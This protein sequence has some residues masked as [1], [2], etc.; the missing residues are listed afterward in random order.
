MTIGFL[1]EPAYETSVSLLAEAVATSPK[2]ELRLLLKWMQVQK[3]FAAMK[4][5]KKPG[6]K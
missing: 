5:I 3:H 6:R 1:K 4:N 2:K